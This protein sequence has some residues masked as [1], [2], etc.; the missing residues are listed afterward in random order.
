MKRMKFFLAACLFVLLALTAQTCQSKLTPAETKLA[1]ANIAIVDSWANNGGKHTG[2]F[3]S[4][5]LAL[6]NP[7]KK[8]R[9]ILVRCVFKSDGTVFG[10]K[11]VTIRAGHKAKIM[12]RGFSRHTE[13]LGPEAVVCGLHPAP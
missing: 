12:V 1:G 10:D 9:K 3:K 6:A 4:I 5:T 13:G 7:T 2:A 8:D 11:T